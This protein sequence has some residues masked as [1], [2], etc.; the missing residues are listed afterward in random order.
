[1]SKSQYVV[2]DWLNENQPGIL[3][4][5]YQPGGLLISKKACIKR[6]LAA[7][8][9]KIEGRMDDLFRHT[10]SKGLSLCRTCPIGEKLASSEPSQ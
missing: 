4:C 5:P 10:L 8:P 3:M 7:R 9:G 6:Y 1:M 2:E